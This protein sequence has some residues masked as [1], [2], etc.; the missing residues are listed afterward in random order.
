MAYAIR[1]RS[2]GPF[3]RSGKVFDPTRFRIL[4]A[5]Q[6]DERILNEKMLEILE[7]EGAKDPLLKGRIV[8]DDETA[9]SKD[10]EPVA[11]AAVQA[12]KVPVQ[13]VA[14][15]AKE[16]LG[17]A[18]K[19]ATDAGKP[20]RKPRPSRAKAKPGADVASGTAAAPVGEPI[21]GSGLQSPLGDAQVPT[22]LDPTIPTE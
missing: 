4:H 20:A 19:P 9:E 22:G 14:P 12:P 13:K 18:D 2:G 3:R 7:V 8:S 1:S 17:D 11:P 5:S 6:V 21:D 15:T 10:A 16:K